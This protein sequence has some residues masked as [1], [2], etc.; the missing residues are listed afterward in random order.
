[1]PFSITTHAGQQ[2]LTLEGSVT[3]RDASQLAALVTGSL[4]EAM[5]LEVETGQ[6]SDI[7]TC[8]LQFLCSLHKTVPDLTF[9]APSFVLLGALDRVQLRRSLLAGRETP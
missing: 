3:V 7:D 1:M 8:I 9:A 6:L 5:P 4:E 2:L